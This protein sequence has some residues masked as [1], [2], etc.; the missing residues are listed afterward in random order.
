[1]GSQ[2]FVYMTQWLLDMRAQWITFDAFW[3]V[4]EKVR[5]EEKKNKNQR[6]KEKKRSEK[7]RVFFSSLVSFFQN[8]S[9]EENKLSKMLLS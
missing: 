5:I 1:M 8:I 4:Y 6:K 9:R 7:W 3:N 2:M